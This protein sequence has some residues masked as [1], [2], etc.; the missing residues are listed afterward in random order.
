[1]HCR[2]QKNKHYFTPLLQNHNSVQHWQPATMDTLVFMCSVLASLGLSDKF[3]AHDCTKP[4]DIEYVPHHACRIPTDSLVHK[5]MVVLQDK[6]IKPIKGFECK[7]TKTTIVSFCGAYSHTKTTGE[8]TFGVIQMVSPEVCRSMVKTHLF[9]TDTMSFPVQIGSISH[10]KMFTHGSIKMTGSN[11]HCQGEPL[12]MLDGQVNDNMLRSIHL[13]VSIH[14]ID[15]TSARGKIIHPGTQTIVAMDTEDH[16]VYK[17]NTI[18]WERIDQMSCNLL[19]VTKM[20]FASV[21]T[22]VLFSNEHRIQF[23]T[24][25]T[26]HNDRC[27]LMI[28]KTKQVG[29]FLADLT[30][31]FS[32]IQSIDTPNINVHA[33]YTTQLNYLNNKLKT[34]LQS[35]FHD[36]TCHLISRT[37]ASTTAWLS[38]STFLRNLGD[39]SIKFNCAKMT[40][41]PNTNSSICYSRLPVKDINGKTSFLDQSTRI[42]MDHATP[43][44][45][46]P[47]LLPTYKTQAGDIVVYA[48]NRKLIIIQ[49]EVA[50]VEESQEGGIFTDELILEW[51][52]YAYIQSFAKNTFSYISQSLAGNRASSFNQN[53]M[54]FLQ[55]QFSK[56]PL[57]SPPTLFW[58]HSLEY[59]GGICSIIMVFV[60]VVNIV[61][62]CVTL[63]IRVCLLQSKEVRIIS[64]MARALCTEMFVITK[65]MGSEAKDSPKETIEEDNTDCNI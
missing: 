30:Q 56:I 14:E 35:T 41:A 40:V 8:S 50:K 61:Y 4:S 1:M 16:G 65:L 53:T 58:G 57:L 18:I 15:L 21:Q 51:F 47:S 32:Q 45:C 10:I 55:D 59:V 9:I 17:A 39:C 52:S 38:A 54:G 27:K 34:N 37:P 29:V 28:I 12:R 42:L 6:N 13:T 60:I 48:P 23:T 43:I 44:P 64:T 20:L 25:D 62:L 63:A 2:V 7:I 3:I 31:D 19:Y 24:L 5:E 11:I 49:K 22:D 46:H 33:H 26:F 36:D